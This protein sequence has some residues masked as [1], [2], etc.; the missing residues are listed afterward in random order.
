MERQ[1]VEC[2]PNI[3]EGRRP[4]V[5]EE[6]VAVVRR[7]GAAVLD[8]YRGAG[9][10]RSVITMAGAPECVERAA[11]SLIEFTKGAIDM[12]EHQGEHPRM[13][14]TDVCPIVPVQGVSLA[15]C[16]EMARRVGERVWNELGIPVYFYEENASS[17]ERRSLAVVRSGEYEG[18]P[19]RLEQPTSRPDL[20]GAVFNARSGAVAIGA[21]PFLIAFN[22]N[23]ASAD[24]RLA[25]RIAERLR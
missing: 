7:Q 11:F 20:G 3:S 4:E 12:R 23:L 22:I 8:V 5:V 6:A 21:R 16:C 2:V 14:A 19:R 15:E 10:N 17:P 25:R 1:L 13:G 24:V 18:L 9:T